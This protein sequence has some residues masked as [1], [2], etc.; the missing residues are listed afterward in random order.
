M[1]PRVRGTA[2]IATSSASLK[3]IRP[4]PNTTILDI[5]RTC[6]PM[7]EQRIVYPDREGEEPVKTMREVKCR[8]HYEID[9]SAKDAEPDSFWKKRDPYGG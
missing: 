5:P 7:I 8:L 9:C 4:V 1:R 2:V 3:P 6:R